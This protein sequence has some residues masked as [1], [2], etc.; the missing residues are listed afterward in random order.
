MKKAAV[1]RPFLW[2]RRKD[3]KVKCFK[4][5][6]VRG[7]V[8]E[9][10]TSDIVAR[11]AAALAQVSNAKTAVI[12]ADGRESSPE[13]KA[14]MISGLRSQGVDVIDV[15]QTGTEEIYFATMH[16]QSDL[17][18]E[19]TASH[20]PIN[21][22]GI[23]FVGR[24]AIPFSD[25]K[26]AQIKQ[27]SENIRVPSKL[28]GRLERKSCLTEYCEHLL[29]YIDIKNVQSS[30]LKIVTNAGNGVAGH[31]I[32]ALEQ[33]FQLRNIPVSFIKL[34]HEPDHT[35]PNGIPNPLLPEGRET[36]SR[37][38]K[39]HKAD[40]G[41][42]WDG[43]FDRCFFFDHTG[44]FIEGYYIVGLLAEAF[45]IKHP[46][47]K[48]I[49]DPR[50]IWNTQKII[51]DKCGEAIQS[52]TGHA[53]IK[54]KMREVDAIYGGEMSAHHY[55]RE[56]GYCDSGMIPWLLVAEIMQVKQCSLASLIESMERDFPV[57]GELNF[58]V[59]NIESCMEKVEQHY[60]ASAIEIEYSD[61]L[62][63][64]FDGW[65]FNLRSSN[66]EPLVR[67]NVES[68]DNKALLDAKVREIK[69][70]IKQ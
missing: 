66:T 49:H 65:R 9:S 56:F 17:G 55:F 36:T 20:N 58:E 27:L 53:Y 11:I 28:T 41:L 43:D 26:F 40:F 24:N 23:K 35:F 67:L 19:I 33:Q 62:S 31:V 21:Y 8:G 38:V 70:L 61:G 45:L 14:A 63:M 25:E 51:K 10:L 12:G 6:D 30:P 59:S 64:S 15:G 54:Q 69:E 3:C 60:Q 57:S 1:E 18:I 68:R 52:K 37:A 39:K 22:N 34:M 42:A 5:Y 50:S 48:I 7:I 4:K 13:F 47:Q 32:D 44:K 46:Q 29:S 16:F 2:K